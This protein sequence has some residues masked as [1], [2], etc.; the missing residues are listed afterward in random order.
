M[1]FEGTHR[2]NQRSKIVAHMH[3]RACMCVQRA[4]RRCSRWTAPVGNIETSE[5]R[6]RPWQETWFLAVP[7][8]GFLALVDRGK[9]GI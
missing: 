2:L 1:Q 5:G 9:P 3:V 8:N 7:G 4:G 6:L